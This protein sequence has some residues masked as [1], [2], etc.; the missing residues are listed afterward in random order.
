M[1]LNGI[2][3]EVIIGFMMA[4][5]SLNHCRFFFLD[6]SL[7]EIVKN[8]ELTFRNNFQ[9]GSKIAFRFFATPRLNFFFLSI[10]LQT[11]GEF[12]NF[13]KDK[14]MNIVFCNKNLKTGRNKIQVFYG[15]PF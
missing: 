15:C 11:V 10:S 7:S 5:I 2:F 6:S 14:K 13:R 9:I 8:V 12:K 3:F 4:M 1:L